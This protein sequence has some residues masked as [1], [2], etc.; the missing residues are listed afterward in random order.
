MRKRE[1]EDTRAQ[2]AASVLTIVLVEFAIN[3]FTRHLEALQRL[4]SEVRK[5]S[6][7][8]QEMEISALDSG[9]Y[10]RRRIGRLRC[11]LWRFLLWEEDHLARM[12]DLRA[13]EIAAAAVTEAMQ[14]VNATL[15]SLSTTVSALSS[16]TAGAGTGSPSGDA[17]GRAFALALRRSLATTDQWDIAKCQEACAALVQE[18]A[19][20]CP[21]LTAFRT[22]HSFGKQP[23][24]LLEAHAFP[25]L[26]FV[27]PE[28]ETEEWE[29]DE[30]PPGSEATLEHCRVRVHLLQARVAEFKSFV[31]Y[32][33]PAVLVTDVLQPSFFKKR[34]RVHFEDGEGEERGA[35][36][37]GRPLLPLDP[38][39]REWLALLGSEFHTVNEEMLENALCGELAPED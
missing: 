12:V 31:K 30:L 3:W 17:L 39:R 22:D 10:V 25:E 33:V 20:L 34:K 13:L 19:L 8:L 2:P 16:G 6:D 37:G 7:R 32:K 26:V 14:G 18:A 1:S 38:T 29:L 4:P 21:H 36:G 35:S 28:L 11:W 27:L 5:E 15:R 9:G 23:L 24:R